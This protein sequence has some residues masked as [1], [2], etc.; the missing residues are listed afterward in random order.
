MELQETL[1]SSLRIALAKR[2]MNQKDLAV[3]MDCTAAYISKI[4]KNGRLSVEKLNDVAV[5]LNFALW[6]FIKLGEEK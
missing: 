6:E 1:E 2:G 4:M 3:Q 5:A